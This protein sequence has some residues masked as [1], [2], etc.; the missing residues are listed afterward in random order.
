MVIAVLKNYAAKLHIKK[1]TVAKGVGQLELP[2]IEL[3][4]DKR[5]QAALDAYGSELRIN[6][7]EAPVLEFYKGRDAAEIMAKMTKFLKFVLTFSS[8]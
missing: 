8:L 5:V 1:I 2:S 6:M 7:T 3:I 4:G